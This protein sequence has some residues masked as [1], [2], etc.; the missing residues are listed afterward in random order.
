MTVTDTLKALQIKAAIIADSEVGLMEINVAVKHSV[1]TLTG[2]VETEEQKH[3]AEELASEIDGIVEVRNELKV[4]TAPID[5]SFIRSSDEGH[6]GYGTIENDYGDTGFSI[7][8]G[9][10]PPGPGIPTT[11]Q[12]PGVFSDVDIEAEINSKL[13]E[14]F[15][16][17][18]SNV[19][20]SVLNQI[21]YLKG[22]VLSPD[23]IDSLQDIVLSVRG[24]M[25][26]CSE[27]RIEE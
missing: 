25:G 1:A 2:E 5:K 27:L 11:E 6:F 21:V 8:G 23:D 17:D 3:I 24:V 15:A 4:V 7:S 13:K 19:S 10:A 16:V 20:A 22:S 18:T 14:Q 26:V 12:F 9:Y